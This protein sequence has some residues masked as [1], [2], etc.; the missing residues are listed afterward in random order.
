[1]VTLFKKIIWILVAGYLL[2]SCNK[3]EAAKQQPVAIF[4]EL[5]NVINERY[6]LFSV[7]IINWDSVHTNYKSQINNSMSDQ[8]LFRIL[9]NMLN[10]LKDGHVALISPADTAV[11]AGFYTNYPRNFN[12]NN[13]IRN[14]LLNDYKTEG[15]IIYKVVA[16]TG[17]I[18]YRSFAENITDLQLDNIFTAM[19]NVK[20]MIIDVRGNFGGNLQNARLLASRFIN[21]KK[22]I[23]YELVK[24]GKGK[25]D[26]FNPQPFYLS[27]R[28][29]VFRG[30]TVILTN[31]SCFSS[32]N[33]FVLYLSD[34]LNVQII[35]DVT[36]GG[37]GIPNN[38]ILQ[39][40]WVLQFTATKTLSPSNQ[41]VE[42]GIAPIVN[43]IITPAQE[44]AGIDPILEKAI[45]ILR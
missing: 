4:E 3:K 35:G 20:G 14:Y 16:Q 17:Y 23:K 18:L 1:M 12:Y 24:S 38:Y 8:E 42:N 43:I 29:T 15:P 44:A 28:A 33:D 21:S 27:P 31:R 45:E 19:S 36:G 9:S 40:G 10:E 22:L 39:N 41:P 25:N 7:K 26:F 6:A 37:G 30:K 11:Y 13:V 2:F 5:W 34:N 32:C